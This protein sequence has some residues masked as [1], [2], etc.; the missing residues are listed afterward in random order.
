MQAAPYSADGSRDASQVRVVSQ[1]LRGVDAGTITAGE[2]NKFISLASIAPAVVWRSLAELGLDP[3]NRVLNGAFYALR[4]G[5]IVAA[6]E[7]PALSAWTT[8]RWY[9]AAFL[10]LLLG[11]VLIAL[12]RH[13]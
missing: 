7:Q 2:L 10:A 9:K 5:R 4:G 11:L 8:S 3:A 12:V 6:R 13:S 1:L